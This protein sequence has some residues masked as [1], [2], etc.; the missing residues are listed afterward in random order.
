VF[1]FRI[2]VGGVRQETTEQTRIIVL[3]EDHEEFGILA[4]AAHEVV[5]LRHDDLFAPPG[6]LDG[7]ARH[8]LRGITTD[9]LIVIDGDALLQDQR[10]VINQGDDSGR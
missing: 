6:S 2:L 3:G 10:L 8:L 5:V 9:A 7:T 1:D 4:D